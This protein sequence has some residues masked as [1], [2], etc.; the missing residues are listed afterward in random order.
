M[1]QREKLFRIFPGIEAVDG[2]GR[3]ATMLPCKNFTVQRFTAR[4]DAEAE[5]KRICCDRC[6][7][8]LHFVIDLDQPAKKLV[9]IRNHQL[10]WFYILGF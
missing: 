7:P 9:R 6:G 4:K 3:F 10:W 2:Y 1:N 5:A 8:H